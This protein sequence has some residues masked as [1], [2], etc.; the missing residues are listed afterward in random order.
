MFPSRDFEIIFF[1]RDG[2]PTDP[3][4]YYG[5]MPERKLEKKN[6]ENEKKEMRKIQLNFILQ[7]VTFSIKISQVFKSDLDFHGG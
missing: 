4:P 7:P 1:E 3:M 6:E 5:W 2:K